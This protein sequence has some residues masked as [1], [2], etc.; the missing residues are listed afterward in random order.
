M[1]METALV[2]WSRWGKK[3]REFHNVVGW[4][5]NATLL[6]I[7]RGKDFLNLNRGNRSLDTY[8][9]EERDSSHDLQILGE[10]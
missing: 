3:F 5:K 2:F 9:Q 1:P 7:F 4:C 8:S 10:F 6:V